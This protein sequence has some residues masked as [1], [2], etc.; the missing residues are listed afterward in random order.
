ME[1]LHQITRPRMPREILRFPQPSAPDD[2]EKELDREKEN[3]ES[4][5]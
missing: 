4:T 2:P 3:V 1:N 5:N